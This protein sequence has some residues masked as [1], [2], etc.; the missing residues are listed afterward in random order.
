[1]KLN[2]K[3]YSISNKVYKKE[4]NEKLPDIFKNIDKLLLD[5]SSKG[6]KDITLINIDYY[7]Y[8]KEIIDHYKNEGLFVARYRDGFYFLW[9][10]PESSMDKIYSC[11]KF[12]LSFGMAD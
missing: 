6:C 2:D 10:K 1:M 11:I 9:S 12:I 8:E 3:L 4:L 5:A 7:I